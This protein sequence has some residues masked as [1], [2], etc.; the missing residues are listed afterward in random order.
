MH[1][2]IIHLPLHLGH[3]AGAFIQ[4]DDL[5]SVHLSEERETKIYC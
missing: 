1:T 5:Q 3:L 2:Y 4:K